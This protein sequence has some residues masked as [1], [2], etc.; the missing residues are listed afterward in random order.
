MVYI[1]VCTQLTDE[2]SLTV[3]IRVTFLQLMVQPMMEISGV[4][5]ERWGV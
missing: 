4:H 5:E 2:N 1:F 3:L